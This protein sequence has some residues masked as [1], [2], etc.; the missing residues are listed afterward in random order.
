MFSI[1]Y[2]IIIIT[3]SVQFSIF[4]YTVFRDFSRIFCDLFYLLST[5]HLTSGTFSPSVAFNNLIYI[6]ING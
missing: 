5:L 2:T 1:F 4:G 3:I 6:K